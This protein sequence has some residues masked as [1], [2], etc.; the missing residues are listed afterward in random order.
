MRND[1]SANP[2]DRPMGYGFH[3]IAAGGISNYLALLVDTNAPKQAPVNWDNIGACSLSSAIDRVTYRNGSQSIQ[4]C[5][6]SSG[7]IG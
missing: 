1:E 3:G 6:D 5:V 4:S 2:F 7:P